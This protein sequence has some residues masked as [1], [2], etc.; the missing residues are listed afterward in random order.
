MLP[1]VWGQKKSLMVETL[2]EII[3]IY[4]EQEAKEDEKQPRPVLYQHIPRRDDRYSE[5]IAK[6][7]YQN[8][9][10]RSMWDATDKI[11]AMKNTLWIHEI[12]DS[13]QVKPPE[14]HCGSATRQW[15]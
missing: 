2:N 10:C 15:S 14:I 1:K 11:M 3:T 6:H 4:Y 12:N 13:W 7:S 8:I 5:I 9:Q